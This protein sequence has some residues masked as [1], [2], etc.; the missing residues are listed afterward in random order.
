M[1][2]I[3]EA[4]RRASLELGRDVKICCVDGPMGLPYTHMKQNEIAMA[5][6]AVDL[7]LAQI[8]KTCMETE[9]MVPAILVEG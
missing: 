8:N 1:P 9:I 5:D 7:L 4:A 2:P 6:K 3:L